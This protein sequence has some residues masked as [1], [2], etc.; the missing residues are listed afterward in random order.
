M[1]LVE[2]PG[3]PPVNEVHKTLNGMFGHVPGSG[4]PRPY[5]FYKARDR[6]LVRSRVLP[7]QGGLAIQPESP[8]YEEGQALKIRVVVDPFRRN[9]NREIPIKEPSGVWEWAQELLEKNGVEV[10]RLS[11]QEIFSPPAHSR[12]K[13]A[14]VP[15][16][17]WEVEA[18]IEV[19]DSDLFRQALERGV[20]RK[21]VY[22]A[23]MI[24]VVR[25]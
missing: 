4:L 8:L 15:L 7:L 19:T 16:Y 17:F 2:I 18:E 25:G 5:Q 13:A 14:P 10:R 23:G 22:G 3:N 24:R 6:V 20:G 11:V 9:K 1:Y 21:K 12:K